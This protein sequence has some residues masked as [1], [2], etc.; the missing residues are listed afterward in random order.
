MGGQR[1][2]H[3]SVRECK[4][5]LSTALGVSFSTLGKKGRLIGLQIS[6]NF[7]S[8]WEIFNY[9]LLRGE[10]PFDIE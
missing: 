9:F 1:R 2:G 3:L 5:T 6:Q 8:V 7:N 10:N 4:S